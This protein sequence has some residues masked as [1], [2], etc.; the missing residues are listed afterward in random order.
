MPVV[1]PS[2]D[3]DD[4]DR[5]EPGSG[6]TALSTVPA[7]G[8]RR[9]TTPVGALKFFHGPMDCG[10]STL[11]LQLDHNHTRQG[12]RGL[13]LTRLDRSRR[14]QI[15]S[16]MGLS[17]PAVEVAE[18]TD[19]AQL[20]RR[21]W[22]AGT[23]VDYLIVDEVQFFTPAQIDQL[24]VL[25]DET[26][27]DVYTFGITTDFRGR[28]FPATARLVELADEVLPL[29]VEVLC[30]CGR[31]GRFNARVV[32]GEMV[33]TGDT[34]VVADTEAPGDQDRQDTV[35]YQVLCRTHHRTGDLGPGAAAALPIET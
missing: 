23:R 7:A 5:A 13:L 22:A 28:L 19:L 34:V 35:R 18:D 17:R 12:R 6:A 24:A 3:A 33:R 16:R 21:S 29:Q 30:W 26:Q 27:V 4:A 25:A 20:V 32:D 11:A 9:G 1:P 10:K 8:S 15:S 31:P 2:D 14:P